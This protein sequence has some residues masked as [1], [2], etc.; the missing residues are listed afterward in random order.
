MG[1]GPRFAARRLPESIRRRVEVATA[2]AWESLVETHVAHAG[3]FVRLLDDAVPLEDALGRYLLEMDLGD[4]IAAAV[5]T[6]VLVAVE[7]DAE[8]DGAELD[9]DAADPGG[10]ADEPDVV[11]HE[12]FDGWRRFRPD[13]VVESVLRRQRR[14][15]EVEGWVSLALARSEEAIIT[16]HVDNAITFAALL[17]EQ[18][19]LDSAVQHYL[20]AVG[21]AGGRAQAV[22]QRTMARLADVHLPL[23]QAERR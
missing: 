7:A 10:N 20:G 16:T 15:D 22:H 11:A 18:L 4:S 9:S 19:D 1:P 17:E 6:R 21:L 14:Q 12:R 23:P 13:R 3:Y 8:F 5:R 2:M